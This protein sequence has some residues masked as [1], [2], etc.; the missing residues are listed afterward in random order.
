MSTVE[1]LAEEA[2]RFAR[3]PLSAEE[4]HGDPMEQPSLSA[5]IAHLLCTMSPL[6]AWL[7]H[8]RLNPDYEREEDAKFDVGTVAHA[9]LLQGKDPAEVVE[10][11]DADD[12]RTKAAK[13]AR[14]AARDAGKVPLLSKQAEAV[15]AMLS[16]TRAQMD[17]CDSDPR[18]FTDGQPEQTLT[19]QE[20]NGVL[21]RAR[22]DWLRDDLVTIDDYKTTSASANPERWTRTMFQIGGDVQAAFYLRGLR[23]VTGRRATFRFV[24]QETFP[25]YALSVVVPSEAAL[26]V[27]NAKVE[28]ALAVWERCLAS[29]EWP[30]YPQERAYAYPPMWEAQRWIGRVPDEAPADP[31]GDVPF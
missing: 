2:G 9:L 5:S 28:H 31:Y 20:P 23:A 14:D 15:A 17:A 12:W 19:W 30:A 13:E 3:A 25:P 16:A 4:Y 10:I 27:G 21:C 18:L 8:P 11:V 1:H 29:G 7:A 6:H 24:V 22:L 26:E